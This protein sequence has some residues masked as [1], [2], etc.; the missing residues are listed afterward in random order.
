MGRVLKHVFDPLTSDIAFNALAAEQLERTLLALM[1]VLM[2]EEVR[3]GKYCAALGMC[4]RYVWMNTSS[5]H[6]PCFLR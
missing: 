1:P 6:E 2:D 4:T 5:R 3:F